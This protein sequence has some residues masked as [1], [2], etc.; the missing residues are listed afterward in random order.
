MVQDK[1]NMYVGLSGFTLVQ[2]IYPYT[3]LNPGP[4]YCSLKYR[5]VNEV[6]SVKFIF[7]TAIWIKDGMLFLHDNNNIVQYSITGT[8][9]EHNV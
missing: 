7:E 1:P 4:L 6:S 3:N 8:F 5:K 2:F 9:K